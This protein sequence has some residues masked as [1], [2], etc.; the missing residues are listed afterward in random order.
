MALYTISEPCRFISGY[1][2]PSTR[3]GAGRV[4]TVPNPFAAYDLFIQKR[5]ESI[6][7]LGKHLLDL[8]ATASPAGQAHKSGDLNDLRKQKEEYREEL[9]RHR[10][11][12]FVL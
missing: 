1:Q 5:D 11:I 10:L 4:N 7:P 2:S 9:R 8:D 3:V 6:H 12:M